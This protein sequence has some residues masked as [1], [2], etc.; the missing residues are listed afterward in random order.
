MIDLRNPL[1]LLLLNQFRY[2]FV[3]RLEPSRGRKVTD[4][5]TLAGQLP[6]PL[7]FLVEDIVGVQVTISIFK[8]METEFV[9]F[10]KV[11][12]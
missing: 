2:G 3:R 9:G 5:L 1:S 11:K 6:F 8:L 10:S 12:L 4:R 7:R